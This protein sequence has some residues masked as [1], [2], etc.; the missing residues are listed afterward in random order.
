M[1]ITE[2]VDGLRK[3]RY[4]VWIDDKQNAEHTPEYLESHFVSFADTLE[5]GYE[6]CTALQE[7]E[8]STSGISS[9]RYRIT[10]LKEDF[11]CSEDLN[12]ETMSRLRKQ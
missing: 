10:G 9:T 8:R 11:V 7:K 2:I 1:Q 3:G 12:E 5:E 6:F 4:V